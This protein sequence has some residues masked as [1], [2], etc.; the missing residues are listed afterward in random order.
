[1]DTSR[2]HHGTASV[3]LAEWRL[4]AAEDFMRAWTS[5]QSLPSGSSSGATAVV[6]HAELNGK[7][8]APKR[9]SRLIPAEEFEL[10]GRIIDKEVQSRLNLTHF[11]EVL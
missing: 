2:L 3:L 7:M 11:Q 9:A 10:E 1:M 4:R 5:L 8:H 6:L